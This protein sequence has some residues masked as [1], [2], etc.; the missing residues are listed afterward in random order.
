MSLFCTSA[1]LLAASG[2][3]CSHSEITSGFFKEFS[4]LVTMLHDTTKTWRGV[5]AGGAILVMVL[6]VIWSWYHACFGRHQT[7]STPG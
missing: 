7:D 4:P 2:Y 3:A 5:I 6:V 1:G